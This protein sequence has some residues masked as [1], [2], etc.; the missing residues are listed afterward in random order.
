MPISLTSEHWAS[1][2]T[3]KICACCGE[4]GRLDIHEGYYL[5]LCEHHKA[6]RHAG[7]DL[8]IWLE[9]YDEVAFSWEKAK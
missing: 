2:A 5:T 3:V 9:S 1:T 8:A 7:E 4:P 6:M